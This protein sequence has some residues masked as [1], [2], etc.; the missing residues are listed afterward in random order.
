MV[1]AE[2]TIISVNLSPIGNDA[3]FVDSNGDP[4][5]GGLLYTYVAGSSTPATT[6]TTS[7]GSTANANPVVLGS[8]GYPSSAGSVVE[9]WLTAG[10]SYKLVLKTS[11]GTTLWTRD[12][13]SGIGDTSGTS[14]QDQWVAG[15]TPTYISATSFSL[16]GDQTSTF[17]VGRRVKT[18]NSGGTIYSTISASVFGALTTVTV[19]NDSGTLDSGLSAVYYS[20]LSNTNGSLPSI[21]A[22]GDLLTLSAAGT[23]ARLAVG[24]NG[25]IPMANSGIANGL[26]YV[27]ALGNALWGCGTANGTDAVN[28]INFSAG[29]CMDSTNAV[30]ITCAAMAGKQ[31]DVNWAPGA[32]T[33]MRNSGVAIANGTYH[34]YAVSKAD[35]TQ[36]YYAHTSTTV[37]T[38][39]AALQAESGG[40]AYIYA[41]RIWSIVRAG[42]TILAYT[43]D[44]DLG[45]LTTPVQDYSQGNPGN[46]AVTATLAS[47]PTGINVISITNFGIVDTGTVESAYVSDLATSD[48]ASSATA[49]P[50]FSVSSQ[51][52]NNYG[53]RMLRIRTNTSAQIRYR[54]QTGGVNSTVKINTLAWEDKRGRG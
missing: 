6:Y 23:Y 47:I 10:V 5:S 15:P 35:G 17:T 25:S 20:Q 7:A 33:G 38:V 42:A 52:A 50:G 37:A 18:T 30:W 31:L 41:R 19:V 39:I 8:G 48:L 54:A 1:H 46:A 11:T 4:L 13:I 22:I 27:A 49:A 21:R 16:V 2:E 51:V 32:A 9:I 36:D 24:A 40:S 44:G 29:G 14:S 3:P 12:N 53:Y 34:L 45:E 28:D 43:Q 26:G